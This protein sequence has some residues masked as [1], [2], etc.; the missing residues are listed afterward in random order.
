M[1]RRSK[2]SEEAAPAD[3]A[4]VSLD[5]EGGKGRPTPKRREAEAAAK[6]R[7]RPPR[8]R[9]EQMQRQ[10]QLRSESSQRI[11]AGMKAGEEKYLLPRDKGPMRRFIRDFVDTRFS[12][13]ELVI[14]LMF[15]ALFVP[16]L[17]IPLFVVLILDLVIMR[18]RLRKQL[19]TRFP[20]ESYKGTTF[21]AI[22]RSMQLRFMRMPK[23]QMRLGQSLPDT[24]R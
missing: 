2:T 11:R 15:I 16:A 6:A 22:T 4:A 20:G 21:Y 17:T 23:T 9:K 14:P 1:F 12:F 24:Y 18:F 5:K 8:T 13:A 3:S 19:T 7:N 10:R